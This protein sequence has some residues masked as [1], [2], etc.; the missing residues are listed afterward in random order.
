MA[1][2]HQ[3]LAQDTQGKSSATSKPED[4]AENSH[5]HV[6]ETIPITL[7]ATIISIA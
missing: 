6:S 7:H 1:Y 4:E 5:K 3:R 2:L